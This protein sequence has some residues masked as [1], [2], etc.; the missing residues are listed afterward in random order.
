MH[1][2][3]YVYIEMQVWHKDLDREAEGLSSMTGSSADFSK[4]VW[5]LCTAYF[6]KNLMFF[7]IYHPL[8]VLQILIKKISQGHRYIRKTFS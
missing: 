5:D 4:R 1:V 7:L 3:V 6:P 2:Y 8:L